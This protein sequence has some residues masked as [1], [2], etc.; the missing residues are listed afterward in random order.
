VVI[1][2]DI[3]LQ[4]ALPIIMDILNASSDENIDI[5]T[6][7]NAL[8][9]YI[10]DSADEEQVFDESKIP[11]G[12]VLEIS[13]ELNE[14]E[15]SRRFAINAVVTSEA[16]LAAAIR[17]DRLA[18]GIEDPV[19]TVEDSSASSDSSAELKLPTRMK[20]PGQDDPL[21]NRRQLQGL[22]DGEIDIDITDFMAFALVRSDGSAEQRF[23]SF[24]PNLAEF[25]GTRMVINFEFDYPLEVSKGEK[26]DK[27]VAFFTDPRLLMDPVTGMFI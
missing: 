17:A 13:D 19:P 9:D 24:K 23:L 25:D 8:I 3:G 6:S 4:Q 26:P 7:Q 16:E 20:L 21:T 10:L 11:V 14:E 5:A 18:D 2:E 15:A 12:D 22:V 1:F 27:V